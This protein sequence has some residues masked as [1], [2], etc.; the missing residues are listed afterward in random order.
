MKECFLF[1]PFPARS[2]PQPKAVAASIVTA[3]AISI[4]LAI[5][6]LIVG[7]QGV[8]VNKA[9][10]DDHPF[11]GKVVTLEEAQQYVQR[12]V[13]YSPTLSLISD[14]DVENLLNIES[15]SEMEKFLSKYNLGNESLSVHRTFG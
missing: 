1:Q 12:L 7:N 11:F 10:I 4:A 6:P 5:I 13:T 15:W 8:F 3:W 2:Y 14:T 9:W